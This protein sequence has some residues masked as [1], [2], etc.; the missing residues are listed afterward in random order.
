M[1]TC[2]SCRFWEAPRAGYGVG[3]CSKAKNMDLTVD[4]SDFGVGFGEPF[5]QGNVYCGPKFGCIHHEV[6]F[7]HKKEY[8]L[9][10]LIKHRHLFSD[11]DNEVIRN[12]APE[13]W[14]RI[15]AEESK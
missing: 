10:A 11:K 13:L 15:V 4:V 12:F 8:V 5:N 3:R 6:S 14:D 9:T 2:D 1:N 7:E